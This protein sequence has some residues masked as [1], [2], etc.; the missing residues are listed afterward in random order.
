MTMDKLQQTLTRKAST[1]L[2]LYRIFLTIEPPL[3]LLEFI[4]IIDFVSTNIHRI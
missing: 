1:R 4:Y 2:V 3:T